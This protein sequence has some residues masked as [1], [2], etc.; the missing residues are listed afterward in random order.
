MRPKLVSKI[1]DLTPGQWLFRSKSVLRRTFGSGKEFAHAIRMEANKTSKPPQLCKDIIENFS[2]SGD[3]VYDVFA[4]TGG[5]LLGAQMALR[6]VHGCEIDP[7]QVLAYKK[8]CCAMSSLFIEFDQEAVENCDVFEKFDKWVGDPF[9]DF[10][11]TDPP[12]FDIDRRPKSTR[13][14]RV[15]GNKPRA[16]EPFRKCSFASLDEWI[17]FMERFGCLASK[18][19]K[20]KK[21][22]AF[23]MD[24]AYLNGEYVFLTHLSAEAMKRSGWLPQGE[25][26]WYNEGR[27]P[28]F[29]GFPVKM[30]TNRTHMSVLFFTNTQKETKNEPDRGKGSEG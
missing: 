23:F 26:I 21:Y 4:G 24:D 8:A 19:V 15:G 6:K 1:N 25:Y 3:L 30:I 9:V 7:V 17:G 11:F 20:P 27:R 18:I 12:F 29:F 22:L 10:L 28:G 13:W 16:M 2:K 14:H 5:V